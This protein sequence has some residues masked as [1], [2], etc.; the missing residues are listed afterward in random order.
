MDEKKKYEGA[1]ESGQALNEMTGPA[2]IK[3]QSSPGSKSLFTQSGPIKLGTTKDEVIALG[4]ITGKVRGGKVRD[5]SHI[6]PPLTD[7]VNP[8][9]LIFTPPPMTDYM[10]IPHSSGTTA[11]PSGSTSWSPTRWRPRI[12]SSA[13]VH[14][15][16]SVIGNVIIGPKVF[17]G[18]GAVIRGENEQ[19][20]FIGE[21]TNLQEGVVIRDLPTAKGGTIDQRR[22]VTVR[23]EK[24]TVYIGSK[25][26]VCPQAQVHGPAHIDDNVLIGMQS[27]VFWA[28]VEKGVIVEPG[29]LVINVSIPT[30]VF[31]PA[32]FK[33]T[34]PKTIADLPPLTKQYRFYDLGKEIADDNIEMLE[35]YKT[36]T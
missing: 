26:S 8:E 20:I 36:L 11:A 7:S 23:G 33:A 34:N 10:D 9:P 18:A 21:G 13:F 19:P 22:L 32:G 2:E 4:E 27:L 24:Y 3:T 30:G 5:E 29:C 35:G 16:A 17:I 1:T 15:N 28:K 12:D 25:V 14:P 6:K 31:M